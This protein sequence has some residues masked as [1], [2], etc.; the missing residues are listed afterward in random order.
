MPDHVIWNLYKQLSFEILDRAAELSFQEILAQFPAI[1]ESLKEQIKT[2]QGND[3]NA[4][5]NVLTGK[6]VL[7]KMVWSEED[8]E[9]DQG[10]IV[11]KTAN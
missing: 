5:L 10:Q 2:L 6:D 9:I 8:L 3:K 11:E 4:Q 7:F 1:I